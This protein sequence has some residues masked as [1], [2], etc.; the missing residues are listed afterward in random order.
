MR[1][2]TVLLFT[3]VALGAYIGYGYAAT[4]FNRAALVY[5]NFAAAVVRSDPDKARLFAWD[6]AALNTFNFSSQRNRD[7]QQ[8]QIKFEYYTINSFFYSEDGDTA[9]IDAVHTVRLDPP[10]TSSVFGAVS[11][12]FPERI[13]VEQRDG[14][15]KVKRFDDYYTMNALKSA[16]P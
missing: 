16:T 4:H 11:V 7:L 1:F 3:L 5:Q 15:W 9:T 10:G 12:S 2:R 6:G 13:L 14:L 8:G